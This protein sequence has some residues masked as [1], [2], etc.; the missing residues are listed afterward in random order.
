[1]VRHR[2]GV[3][4]KMVKDTQEDITIKKEISGR[5]RNWMRK[6]KDRDGEINNQEENQRNQEETAGRYQ[7]HSQKNERGIQEEDES[8]S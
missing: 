6:I 2:Q 4:A 7:E 1:M 5:F 3:L 8:R